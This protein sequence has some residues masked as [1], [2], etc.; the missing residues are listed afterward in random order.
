MLLENVL[1]KPSSF[2]NRS[3]GTALKALFPLL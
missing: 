3:F 2:C 1:L